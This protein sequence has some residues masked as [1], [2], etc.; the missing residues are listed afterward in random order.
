MYELFL[1]CPKGLEEVCKKDLK[2]FSGKINILNGGLSTQGSL[3]D[4]YRINLHSRIGMNLLVKLDSFVFKN[5]SDFYKNIYQYKW[6]NLMTPKM[7]FFISTSIINQSKLFNN[8]QFASLKAKDAIVDR[9]RKL[10]NARPSVSK[11][12][13]DL[14][15]R[16][17]IDQNNCILYLNSSGA[18]L[19]RRGYKQSTHKAPLNESLASGLVYL[20]KWDKKTDLIDPMCG[21]GTIC[22]EAA[23]IRQNIAPGINRDFSFQRWMN[24]DK[25][26]FAQLHKNS[27]S[28]IKK[29]SKNNI[30]GYDKDSK[31]IEG[32]RET[33]NQF[34]HNLDL[35]FRIKNISNFTPARESVVITNPPYE[36]RIGDKQ[37]MTEIH[38]GFDKI[39]KNNNTLYAIYPLE[40]DFIEQNYNYKKITDIYNGPIKCG[41]YK[42]NNA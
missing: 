19:Y 16:L 15:I 41:F 34:K 8:S 14:E 29:I 24:Y 18:P 42:I 40:S 31:S 30:S 39:L 1:T 32:C 3:E 2:D 21:S 38:S 13:A 27:I 11:E 33:K 37:A 28:S 25:D 7:T 9:I 12:G 20:S 36:L 23:M 6:E 10:R 4:I 22:F 35:S 26:L 17:I 5:I